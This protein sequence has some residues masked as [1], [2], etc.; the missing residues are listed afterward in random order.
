[1]LSKKLACILTGIGLLSS[2]ALADGAVGDFNFNET[3]GLINIPVA[4]VQPAGSIQ[5]SLGASHLGSGSKPFGIDIDEIFGGNDGTARFIGGLPGN[6]E[7]SAMAFHGGVF[8]NNHWV[9]GAKWLAVPDAPDHPAF[10][11]GVQSL[12]SGPSSSNPHP[13]SFDDPSAFGVLSHSFKFNDDGLGLDLHAGIGTGRLRNGFAGGEFHFT[14]NFSLMGETDGTLESAGFRFT[15]NNRFNFMTVAQFQNDVR[16]GFLLNYSFGVTDDSEIDG[17][18]VRD[19]MEE[20]APS[21]PSQEPQGPD[22]W[23]QPQTPGSTVVPE[24][25][26]STP[27]I[28]NASPKTETAVPVEKMPTLQVEPA[29]VNQVEQLPADQKQVEQPG[30]QQN[31]APAAQQKQQPQPVQKAVEA[32]PPAPVSSSINSQGDDWDSNWDTPAPQTIDDDW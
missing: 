20:Y 9:F 32:K 21:Q 24:P 25:V 7:L 6:V 29:P 22:D 17:P 4:R 18:V 10:A 3:T 8:A 31:Q 2:P 5:V 14:P 23:D 15:I 30:E 26:K 11:I 27:P 16:F 19:E 28:E 12:N 13:A 1:M